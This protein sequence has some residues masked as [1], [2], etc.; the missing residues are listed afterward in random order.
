MF[1]YHVDDG[2]TWVAGRT[3]KI[4]MMIRATQESTFTLCAGTWG[5]QAADPVTV[6]TEW[7]EVTC[8]RTVGVDGGGFVMFQSGATPGTIEM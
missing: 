1:Q 8:K 7:A 2:I 5:G 4:T 6:G 3:Y